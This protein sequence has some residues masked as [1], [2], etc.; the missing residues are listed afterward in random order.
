MNR[1]WDSVI[2]PRGL[3]EVHAVDLFAHRHYATADSTN[4]YQDWSLYDIKIFIDELAEAIRKHRR[5]IRP[6]SIVVKNEDFHALENGERRL[7]TSGR[8]RHWD[9]QNMK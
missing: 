4:P 6:I 9:N 3:L 7:L 1:D 5:S 8:F 2:K